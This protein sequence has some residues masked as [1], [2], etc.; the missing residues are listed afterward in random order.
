MDNIAEGYERDGRKEFIHFLSISK[1]SALETR[2]RFNRA[3]D[4]EYIDEDT[5][6]K[7]VQG[8][9]PLASMINNLINY[10]KTTSYQENKF[11]L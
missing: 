1:S 4:K 10:L 11:K 6:N 9:I 7:N 3:F 8:L 2:S 5:L